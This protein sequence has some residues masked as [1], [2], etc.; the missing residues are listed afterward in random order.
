LNPDQPQDDYQHNE[1][2]NL[3]LTFPFLGAP[4]NMNS[5]DLSESPHGVVQRHGVRARWIPLAI[6]QLS[7]KLRD[8]TEL[9]ELVKIAKVGPTSCKNKCK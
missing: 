2:P 6:L 3:N 5:S 7:K 4:W 1:A 8:R 9:L